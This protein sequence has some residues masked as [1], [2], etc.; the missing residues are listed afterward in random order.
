MHLRRRYRF[1][2]DAKFHTVGAPLRPSSSVSLDMRLLRRL[3]L[4]GND[5]HDSGLHAL[6]E[7]MEC[8]ASVEKLFVWGNDF[9]QASL[10]R[11]GDL[12]KGRFALV[13]VFID[14]QPFVVDGV[15][16]AAEK[17]A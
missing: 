16:H 9:G 13:G 14:V 3:D 10:R 15:Y 7:G 4:R 11:F 6:A 8:N 1:T 17:L 5:I 12:E 2:L